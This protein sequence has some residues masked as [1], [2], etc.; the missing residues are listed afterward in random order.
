MFNCFQKGPVEVHHLCPI[1]TIGLEIGTGVLCL[2]LSK[3]FF[4]LLPCSCFS[5]VVIAPLLALNQLEAILRV[6]EQGFECWEH[7][8]VLCVLLGFGEDICM[9]VCVM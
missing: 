8:H 9:C 1:F 4:L 6:W 5:A 7:A 2:S 3:F